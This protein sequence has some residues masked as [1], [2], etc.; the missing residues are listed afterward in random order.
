MKTI[1]N[2]AMMN[3]WEGKEGLRAM[4]LLYI[5]LEDE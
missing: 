4:N 1:A 2:S 3:V 5:I